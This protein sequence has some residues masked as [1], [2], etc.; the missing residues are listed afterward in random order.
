MDFSVTKI[1]L[2]GLV[3]G[4]LVA[5]IAHKLCEIKGVASCYL[6]RK[7]VESSDD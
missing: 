7:Y 6:I 5:T 2:L 1:K 4:E 3:I